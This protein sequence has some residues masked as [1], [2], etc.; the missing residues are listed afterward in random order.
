MDA[1]ALIITGL[2]IIIVMLI[3]I[4][5]GPATVKL[6]AVLSHRAVVPV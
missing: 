5:N 2:T 3:L 6:R 1:I 4:Y